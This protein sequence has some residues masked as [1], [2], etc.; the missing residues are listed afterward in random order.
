MLTDDFESRYFDIDG[1]QDVVVA[2]FVTKRLTDE[3]NIEQLGHELVALV[4]KLQHRHVVL[5]VNSLDYVTSSVIGKWITLHRR[6]DRA[7]GRMAMC[8]VRD[9]LADILG[10]AKLLQYFNVADDFD[11]A[12]ESCLAARSGE[13]DAAC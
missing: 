3:D 13:A 10:T 6:L 8:R 9:S 5:D 2:R 11:A 7:G 1:D 4:D 12:R